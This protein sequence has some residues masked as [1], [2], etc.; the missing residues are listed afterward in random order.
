M[1]INAEGKARTE[2]QLEGIIA[3]VECKVGALWIAIGIAEADLSLR[4]GNMKARS[5]V[6]PFFAIFPKVAEL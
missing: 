4:E 5:A 1:F 2:E 6:M 3:E